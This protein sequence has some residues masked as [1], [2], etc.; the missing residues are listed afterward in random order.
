MPSTFDPLLRL[1]LQATG[2]NATTWGIKTNTNLDLL[3][4]SIAGAITLNVAGSGDYTLST[5]NGAA[6]ESRQAIL[7]LTGL[8]TGNRTILVPASPKHYT[9][10]NQ[11]TGAFT[12]TLRQSGGTGLVIPRT[13]PVL[14]VCTS[15]TCVDAVGATP[16]TRSLLDD[17][18]AATARA[19][20]GLGSAAILTATATGTSLVTAVDVAAAQSTLSTSWSLCEAPRV[21]SS[22]AQVDFLLP[23]AFRRYRL[24]IHDGAVTAAA[25]NLLLRFSSDGG[26]TFL[27]AASYQLIG[28]RTDGAATNTGFATS[29]ATSIALSPGLPNSTGNPW[30]AEFAINPGSASLSARVRGF[31]I[32][33]DSV[34][35]WAHG[36]WGGAWGGA[37]ARMNAM[38][39]FVASGT[40]SG[41][42]IL[43]GLR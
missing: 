2:E 4:S 3:A 18:D 6:D 7:I 25:Q 34:P 13:G 33:V 16:F 17:A 31:G 9:V 37:T 11:T 20:L 28:N 23:A 15:T 22:V 42:L 30:D 5:V 40:L 35:T 12:V 43:E 10:I 27:S 24:T 41:T 14:T 36:Y 32:G 21:V 26:A 8:L 29:T 19:T 39:V 1:E 38:R